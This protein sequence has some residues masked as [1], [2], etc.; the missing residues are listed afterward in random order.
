VVG[1]L[2]QSRRR[3]LAVRSGGLHWRGGVNGSKTPAAEELAV[4]GGS[5]RRKP[6]RSFF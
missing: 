3:F 2:R 5:R 4:G 6:S 1:D